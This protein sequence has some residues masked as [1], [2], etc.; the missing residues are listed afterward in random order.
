MKSTRIIDRR[1]F[2]QAAGMA[3]ATILTQGCNQ[4]LLWNQQA[5]RKQLQSRVLIEQAGDYKIDLTKK[6]MA[7]LKAFDISLTGKRVLLKPNLVE[8]EKETVINTNPALIGAVIEACRRLGAREVIVGEGPGHRRDTDGLVKESGLLTYLKDT[9]APFSDLNLDDIRPVKLQSRFMKVNSLFFPATVLKADM[10][11]SM[12]KM[13]THH[14][15]GMTLSMKNMFG[16]IPGVKYGWPKNFLHWH[17]IENSILDINST[18]RTHFAI[19]DGITAMEGN[20]PIQGKPKHCGVL[21][22]GED[23]VSVDSTCARIAG[24]LPERIGYLKT[25]AEALGNLDESR[26]QQIGVPISA[27]RQPFEVI[28]NFNHLKS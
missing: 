13:K 5:F 25:A 19:V 24:L 14:W 3:G 8:Y 17:G 11:I 23:L 18:V 2:I 4:E 26:I 27:V 10:I 20:G 1:H 12:P 15:A 9:Q 7:G 22:F 21:V 16:I 6:V 28:P